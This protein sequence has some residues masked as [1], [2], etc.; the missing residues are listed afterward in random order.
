MPQRLANQHPLA[1]WRRWLL[2]PTCLALSTRSPEILCLMRGY[3]PLVDWPPRS[4]F[5]IFLC[6]I[7]G[8]EQLGELGPL[9]PMIL[10]ATLQR[11]GS[12]AGGGGFRKYQGPGYGPGPVD[13][14]S[15]A[16]MLLDR[17]SYPFYGYAV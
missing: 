8:R 1:P 5:L 14:G 10:M 16:E 12:E 11:R 4:V 6:R 2:L 9:L 7:N 3:A 13:A 17:C 15:T